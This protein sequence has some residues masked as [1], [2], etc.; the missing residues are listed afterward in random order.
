M[1]EQ[2][3][4]ERGLVGALLPDAAPQPGDADVLDRII[5]GALDAPLAPPPAKPMLATAA[6]GAIIAGAFAL[7]ALRAAA[8]VE[9]PSPP[10]VSA[11]PAVSAPAPAVDDV[12]TVSVESLPAAVPAPTTTAPRALSATELFARANDERRKAR[13]GEAI[14]DYR[15]LQSRYPN[16]PE[17]R[18]SCVALGRLLLD[19]KG[20]YAGALAQFDRYLASSGTLREEALIGRALALGHLGRSDDE[21][22]AW[23]LLLD[24]YP[25]SIYASQARARL[26]ALGH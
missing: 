8:P 25:D 6:G 7:L 24:D 21:R 12:P 3:L 18:A 22:R 19:K 15:A 20:D 23:K 10:V 16:S 5:D 1:T 14:D 17:A 2:D 26:D 13:D 11:P 9:A 4:I